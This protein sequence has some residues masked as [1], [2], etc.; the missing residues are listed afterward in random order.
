MGKTGFEYAVVTYATNKLSYVKFAF[1]CAQSVVLYNKDIPVYIVTNLPVTVPKGLKNTFI[2]PVSNELAEKGLELKL[3]IDQFLHKTY[4]LFI[5]A[6]CL[7]FGSLEPLFRAFGKN[8]LSVIGNVVPSADWCG[9]TQA[10][11]I[12]K[13]FNLDSLVRFNAGVI[14]LKKSRVNTRLFDEVR[15]IAKNY[16]DYGFIR[17]GKW[18]NEE[19][20]IAI[21]MMLNNQTPA[22][23]NGTYMTNLFTDPMPRIMNV[24]TGERLLK[25][26]AIPSP[27]HRAWY[28]AQ[29]S[30]V[31]L[32]FGSGRINSYPYN[33]QK[34]LLYLQRC[35]FP[36]ALSTVITFTFIHI[37]YR[38]AYWLIGSLRKLKTSFVK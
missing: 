8:D 17:N 7:C 24:L 31:I 35:G 25:N 20:P 14:Y 28:P 1:N 38:T 2:I 9:D 34:L 15:D 10:A 22:A 19:G 21:T 37:P 33:S 26:P 3:Y 6:D 23:D 12:K 13:V 29:Y 11:T 4:T 18:V 16:D 5:D 32:H 36:N 27:R 30:P